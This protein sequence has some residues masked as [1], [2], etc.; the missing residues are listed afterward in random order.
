MAVY[1]SFSSLLEKLGG[2][3][4]ETKYK[5]VDVQVV[6]VPACNGMIDVIAAYRLPNFEYS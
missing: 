1:S 4:S 6:P 2:N 3:H 5:D